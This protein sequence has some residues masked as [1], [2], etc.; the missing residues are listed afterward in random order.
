MN[1][2]GWRVIAMMVETF[3]NQM[4]HVICCIAIDL[5]LLSREWM[6]MGVAGTIINNYYGSFPHSLRETHQ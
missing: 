3:D 1:L 4:A 2:V 6:G 5:L